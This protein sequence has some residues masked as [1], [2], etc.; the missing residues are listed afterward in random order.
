[1]RNILVHDYFGIDLFE[2]WN[3]VENDIPK[4]KIAVEQLLSNSDLP[5][6]D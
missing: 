5:S 4:L 3:A 1:M 2:V 6:E